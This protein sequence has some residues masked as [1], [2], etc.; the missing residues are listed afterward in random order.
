MGLV[1]NT[2]RVM[3][4]RSNTASCLVPIIAT[5]RGIILWPTPSCNQEVA[6]SVRKFGTEC[7]KE[8][9]QPLFRTFPALSF[10]V[11][12]ASGR[13]R[14]ILG[15]QLLVQDFPRHPSGG[16]LSSTRVRFWRNV[17]NRWCGTCTREVDRCACIRVINMAD[18]LLNKRVATRFDRWRLKPE[19]RTQTLHIPRHQSFLAPNFRV[20]TNNVLYLAMVLITTESDQK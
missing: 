1:W 2:L 16:V 17:G 12:E 11:L 20:S 10:A 7:L 13:M 8:I 14:A 6:G 4:Q 9:R 15:A 3:A 18:G 19:L 5:M